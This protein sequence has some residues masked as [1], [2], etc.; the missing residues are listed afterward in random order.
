MKTFAL[1]IVIGVLA[2]AAFGVAKADPVAGSSTTQ[3]THPWTITAGG[4]WS[5]NSHSSTL[6]IVGVDYAFEKSAANSNPILPSIYLDDNFTTNGRSANVVDLGVAVR[7]DYRQPGSSI[8][9]YIGIGVGGYY[10]DVSSQTTGT[11]PVTS[12]S[13]NTTQIGGKV[14]GGV[15]FA[16]NWLVEANY[17]LRQSYKGTDY[18]SYGVALGYRF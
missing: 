18:D 8:T 13:Y 5:T 9:P 4:E 7:Q 17:T 3:A 11:P 12:P 2:I 1:P 14:F 16:S 10:L 15:E 6:G